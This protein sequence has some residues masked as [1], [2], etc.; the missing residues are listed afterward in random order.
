MK[1]AFLLTLVGIFIVGL[2]ACAAPADPPTVDDPGEPAPGIV[3]DPSITPLPADWLQAP[4]TVLTW[5]SS[6]T[7]ED[8]FTNTRTISQAWVMIGSE[9][10]YDDFEEFNNAVY[11]WYDKMVAERDDFEDR[12]FGNYSWGEFDVFVDVDIDPDG[13]WQVLLMMTEREPID[14]NEPIG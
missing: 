9:T 4:N 3:G 6:D 12:G 14:P 1:K 10:D 13:D 8:E 11:S 7:R 2:S 5:Y